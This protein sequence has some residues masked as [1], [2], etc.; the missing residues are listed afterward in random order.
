M[1]S[2]TCV[3]V[4][5]IVA[6]FVCFLGAIYFPILG[7]LALV[8][9]YIHDQ[10]QNVNLLL[11]VILLGASIGACILGGVIVILLAASIGACILGG[12]T[13]ILLGASIGTCILGGV[14][15]ILL[16]ASI[17]TCILG[18]VAGTLRGL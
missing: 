12:V 11:I 10:L 8:F 5:R 2:L 15:V 3:T 4:W 1:C 9:M 13:V 7:V 18:G 6:R 16:G 14:I 17:G